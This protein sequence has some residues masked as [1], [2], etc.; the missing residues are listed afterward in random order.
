MERNDA[1]QEPSH[2]RR[3]D[4]LFS[5]SETSSLQA[6]HEKVRCPDV[7]EAVVVRKSVEP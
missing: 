6:W 2:V 3:A 7:R 5:V 1:Y 4:L